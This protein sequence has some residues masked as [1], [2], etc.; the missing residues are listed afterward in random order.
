[1][2]RNLSWWW[3]LL[4]GMAW[5]QN[6]E[7]AAG[8]FVESGIL[9]VEEA[10][11]LE[12]YLAVSGW[13]VLAEEAAAIPGLSAEAAKRL[14]ADPTWRR[15]VG[16]A[17]GQ[18][19]RSRLKLL[20]DV[21][22]AAGVQP[23]A[24]VA[25]S[26]VGWGMRAQRAGHWGLRLDRG[27][28]EAGVDHVA[29]FALAPPVRGVRTIWGDHAIRWG[30]GLVGWSESPYDGMRSS[31]S[32]QRVTQLARP[33]LSGDAL[34][35]RRGVALLA[36]IAGG[37]AVASF[38]CGVREVRI[39]DG[40]PQTWYRDGQHR[41][42]AERSREEVRPVRLAVLWRRDAVQGGWGVAAEAGRL[43]GSAVPAR[44]VVG[45]HGHRSFRASRWVGELAASPLGL[46][47]SVGAIATWS[48]QWDAYI[49]WERD[50]P[51]H[52]AAMWGDVRPVGGERW[53]WGA[54]SRDM[55][56]QHFVRWEWNGEGLRA[57]WQARGKVGRA[58][59]C[60][61]RVEVDGM[62]RLTGEYRLDRS[63]WGARVWGQIAGAHGAAGGVMWSWQPG[64]GQ[65]TWRVGWSR[66]N[67]SGGALVYRL[68]P[69]AQ[70]WQTAVHSGEGERWWAVCSWP[71]SPHWKCA[72]SVEAERRWGVRA[73][74]DSG[75]WEWKGA[76]RGEGRLRVAYAL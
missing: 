64:P 38:D 60:L 56:I 55:P 24:P 14:E 17:G 73:F 9:S 13:P 49:R 12:D 59:R 33:V 2:W 72:F 6:W 10:G 39:V 11:A 20:W 5:S 47:W 16:S 36:D 70:A 45:V 8:R 43:P 3:C 46:A 4:P 27:P 65:A 57:E 21:R 30:Q 37:E 76:V 31:T 19:E 74:P 22:R 58:G 23:G 48:K 68:E 66:S 35:V 32:A 63:H 1:M 18:D 26:P 67:L 61:A 53:A 34:P 51:G 71:V 15:W 62:W 75:P 25:G 28:G 41:T 50:A 52:P 29:G 42:L 40:V 44:A 69:H 7:G 54:E